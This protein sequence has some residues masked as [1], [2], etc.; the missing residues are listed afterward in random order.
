MGQPAALSLRTRRRRVWEGDDPFH[1]ENFL[2]AALLGGGVGRT[3]APD[4]RHA[5]RCQGGEGPVQPRAARDEGL[6]KGGGEAR[7]V[8]DAVERLPPCAFVGRCEQDPVDV[9]DPGVELPRRYGDVRDGPQD[10]SHIRLTTVADPTMARP[11]M[12]RLSAN[13]SSGAEIGL[14]RSSAAL[15]HGATCVF[16]T[17][18]APDCRSCPGST[19]PDAMMAA[20]SRPILALDQGSRPPH[21]L[22]WPDAGTRLDVDAGQPS[23]G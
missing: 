2:K 9:E 3:D 1:R 5:Q 14:T 16:M 20:S 13:G 21:R 11:I 22:R 8:G 18:Q 15:V 7:G 23:F 4:V 19:D 17:G 6:I 12:R 10:T